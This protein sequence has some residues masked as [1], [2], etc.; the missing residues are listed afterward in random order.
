MNRRK[1]GDVIIVFPQDCVM[2]TDSVGERIGDT[3]KIAVR[4]DAPD[5]KKLTV[6]GIP[7]NKV[8]FG[9]FR[10]YVILDKYEN[11][12][13]FVDETTGE[14][15]VITVYYLKNG[16]K[17]Y[18]ISLDD[19]IW[20]F[21]NLTENKDKYQSMFEDPYMTWL[22]T[23][24]EEFGTKFHLNV[25]Y[26]TDRKGGFNLSQMTD[27]YKD[28]WIANSD[29]LRLSFHATSDKP[30]R[31]YA[32]VSYEQMYFECERVDKEIRRFAGEQCHANTVTTI[33]F[34]EVSLEGTKALRDLGYKA[35][36]GDFNWKV[37]VGADIRMCCNLEQCVKIQQYGF[38]Y[39]KELDVYY[40]NYNGEADIQHIKDTTTIGPLFDEKLGGT[41]NYHFKDICLH[42]QYFHPEF[43][44]HQPDY[45]EK[46][47]ESCTWFRNNGYESVFM[48]DLFEFYTH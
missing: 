10:A 42:E 33:H 40:F 45:Y 47:R 18:R 35:F 32:N 24:H 19:V 28:E 9:V 29:W 37:R 3:L 6:N 13:E 8:S 1:A 26:E 31:P 4:V 15:Q 25:Y 36:V 38:L 48:D 16:Y 30:N 14:K 44:L 27:K 7:L 5:D 41:L 23:I 22:K 21:Q 20:L 43:H 11:T 46:M 17:K 39:D 2:L 12:L 34:G